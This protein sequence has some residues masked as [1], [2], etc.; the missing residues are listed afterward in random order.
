MTLYHTS[1]QSPLGVMSLVADDSNLLGAWFFDQK[2]YQ[3][4]LNDA[5]FL[6]KKTPILEQAINWLDTYFSGQI[7]QTASFL[8][9]NASPFQAKVWNQLQEIPLGQTSSYGA[10]AKAI[11]CASAQAVGGAVSRN[12]L[13]IFVPCHRV[14]A[15]DGSL[16]GYAG[17]LDKKKWLLNHEK[18]ILEKVTK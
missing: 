2:Y 12:P 6:E 16:T 15:S 9:A 10:I 18:T 8:K 17:G 5:I 13:S 14:L 1:Y 7:P 4:G 11:D 3:A